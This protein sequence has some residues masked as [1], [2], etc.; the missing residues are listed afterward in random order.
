MQVKIT[1]TQLKKI[2]QEELEKSLDEIAPAL[3]AGAKMAAGAAGKAAVKQ[4]VRS[5][6]DFLKQRKAQSQVQS[7]TTPDEMEMLSNLDQAL[8]A[9][10]KSGNLASGQVGMLI[11]K[12]QALL[13]PKQG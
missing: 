1:K 11:Q 7:G 9:Y 12:L 6:S 13:T 2:I 4:G 3:A 5:V 8:Q 10:A